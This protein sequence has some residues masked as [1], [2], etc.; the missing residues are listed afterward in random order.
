L[1][2]NVRCSHLYKEAGAMSFALSLILCVSSPVILAA[3]FSRLKP[4]TSL[5]QP[6]W[7]VGHYASTP[8]SGLPESSPWPKVWPWF[9][10]RGVLMISAIDETVADDADHIFRRVARENHG[11]YA[12]FMGYRYRMYQAVQHIKGRYWGPYW[13]KVLL[14]LREMDDPDNQVLVWLDSDVVITNFYGKMLERYIEISNTVL[15]GIHACDN[16]SHAD[17]QDKV[18]EGNEC[19]GPREVRTHVL[20]TTNFPGGVMNTGIMIVRNTP[21]A[22]AVLNSMLVVGLEDDAYLADCPQADCCLH[23]QQALLSVMRNTRS[24]MCYHGEWDWYWM[25]HRLFFS[26]QYWTT[27]GYPDPPSPMTSIFVAEQRVH[28]SL[29]DGRNLTGDANG[30]NLNTFHHLAFVG[31]EMSDGET[32]WIDMIDGERKWMER[33][34]AGHCLGFPDAKHAC[35]EDLLSRVSK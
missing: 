4:L 12:D 24:V 14:L 2:F 23:E 27:L 19:P 30:M 15:S 10:R 32:K 9:E 33:D 5:L 26:H 16:M 21:E 34:F 20:V 35:L 3:L 29:H 6:N 28:T 22:R 8:R 17:Y 13:Y 11:P 31:D 7:V 18:L 1:G 25:I